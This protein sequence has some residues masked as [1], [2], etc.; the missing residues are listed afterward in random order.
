MHGLTG[1]QGEQRSTILDSVKGW[2]SAHWKWCAI[3]LLPTLL[4]ASY[5]Y[6]I[7]AD[8]YE[9]E[10]HFTVRTAS[11]PTPQVSGV[12]QALTLIGGASS[13]RDTLIVGDYISSHDAVDALQKHIHLIDIFRRPEADFVSRLWP[14]SPTP[15]TLLKY[16]EGKV[17]VKIGSEDGI[18]TLKVRTF[19]PADSMA[20]IQQLLNLSEARVNEINKRNYTSAVGFA[21]KQLDE[22]EQDV[23]SIQGRMTS[24]RQDQSDVSPEATSQARVAMVTELQGQLAQARA[25]MGAMAAALSPD[26]PQLVA[27]RQRVAAL[28]AQ[29]EAEKA[30]TSSGPGNV[31]TG[32][33]AFESLKLRQ[34]FAAK[35]YDTAAAALE[36][37]REE[38][39]KQ[40]L[41]IVRLVEPNM[42][43]KALYPK[44]LKIVLTIFCGLLLVY[45]IGWLIV[46]GVREHSV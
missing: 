19:R 11:G 14:S 2:F 31:A 20:I 27:L 10:A 21:H 33:G 1:S 39:A 42:P 22:A 28:S 9:S 3:V 35:R 16:Y 44:R 32:L 38:A 4:T 46:A 12:S 26:S 24:F 5:Y 13:D 29:V 45:G 23:A 36:K 30:R 34:D 18:A 40:Q 43:V 6:L 41:F 7:A 17:D 25:Q 37:A 8:Q 15:E